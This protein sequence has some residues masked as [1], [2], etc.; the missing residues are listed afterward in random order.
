MEKTR[1][2]QA[3][4]RGDRFRI[5]YLL[6]PIATFFWA[7]GH[8]LGRIILEEVH[9]F[10]LGSVTLTVGFFCLLVYCAVT[11]RIRSLV[12]LPKKDLLVSLLLGILGFFLYQIFTFSALQRIPAS[13]NAILISTNVILIMLFSTL[14]LSERIGGHRVL[15]IVLAAAGVVFVIFNR[16]FTLEGRV[17]LLGCLFSICAAVVFSLYS[18]FG[19]RILE[20]ND[21]IMIVMLALLSGAVLLVILTTLTVGMG[22]LVHTGSYRWV[23][24]LILGVGMIGVGYPIW[25]FCLK[26]LPASQISIFIYTTPM[27][28][29]ILSLIILRERFSWLFWI[30]CVLI[31]GGIVTVTTFSNRTE[32]EKVR[33]VR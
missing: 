9:P 28:A 21:P 7:L 27:F 23:L 30:G 20:E 32:K 15:G 5:E 1:T 29:V 26:R 25:F 3:E 13:M 2:A 11:G 22:G 24:M 4:G 33:S 10:Q 19:K 14:L 8:P 17:G 16:G 18:V 6:M 31:L 12:K